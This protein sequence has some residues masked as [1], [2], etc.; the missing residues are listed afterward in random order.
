MQFKYGPGLFDSENSFRLRMVQDHK[1]R[2]VQDHKV[3]MVQDHM[4]LDHKS[5]SKSPEIALLLGTPNLFK[6]HKILRPT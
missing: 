4:V 3:L 5:R 6:R 2:M 1:V